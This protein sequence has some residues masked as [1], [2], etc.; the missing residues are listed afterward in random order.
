MFTPITSTKGGSRREICVSFFDNSIV[1][2]RGD[3]S[4]SVYENLTLQLSVGPDP[5]R[6]GLK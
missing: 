1:M 4:S 5:D 3:I 2:P 6:S